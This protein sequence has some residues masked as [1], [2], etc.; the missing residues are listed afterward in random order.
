[1]I[2]SINCDVKTEKVKDEFS[3]KR[4]GHLLSVD[5]CFYLFVSGGEI[6]FNYTTSKF[7]YNTT[8]ALDG[9]CN[10]ELEFDEDK[11]ERP[12]TKYESGITFKIDSDHPDLKSFNLNVTTILD[13]QSN[14]WNISNITISKSEENNDVV[15]LVGDYLWAPNNQS[16]SC[17]SFV[18]HKSIHMNKQEEEMS[19]FVKLFKEI[20]FS[21]FQIQPFNGTIFMDSYDC[22]AWFTIG[23]FA[24]LLVLLLFTS[25]LAIGIYYIMSIKAND[26]FED[27]KG[28]PLVIGNTDN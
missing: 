26:R 16:Y 10:R 18:L 12:V 21:Y 14:Y 20:S 4:F 1:M 5:E 22:E 23:T 28:K 9:Y 6:N 8:T 7:E 11:K 25:I 17:G 27:P 13:V 24:G 15:I 2:S 3:K 19:K